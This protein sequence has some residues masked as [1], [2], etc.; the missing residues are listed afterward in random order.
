MYS[1]LHR[2]HANFTRALFVEFIKLVF[3]SL[4]HYSR[5][6][7]LP[8]CRYLVQQLQMEGAD[9]RTSLSL[10]HFPV[11][12]LAQITS[13]LS[14][15]ITLGSL[16][17][18]G[19]RTLG[20]KLEHGGV[21][22]LSSHNGVGIGVNFSLSKRFN[23]LTTFE[24][25]DNAAIGDTM[26]KVLLC[27]PNCILNLRFGSICAPKLFQEIVATRNVDAASAPRPIL[28]PLC[29]LFPNLLDLHF[30]RIGTLSTLRTTE[31]P[32]LKFLKTLPA[33]LTSLSTEELTLISRDL[34][35]HIPPRLQAL[36]G[37]AVSFPFES[38][39]VPFEAA[40]TL[41]TVNIA[42]MD[43]KPARRLGTLAEPPLASDDVLLQKFLFA[44][45][46]NVTVTTSN[47]SAISF[48][49]ALELQELTLH[50]FSTPSKMDFKTI[51][52]RLPPSLTKL[53]TTI[54]IQITDDLLK[55]SPLAN[56]RELHLRTPTVNGA[57]NSIDGSFLNNIF[58]VCPSLHT[59]VLGA[60]SPGSGPLTHFNCGWALNRNIKL[61][62]LE[63]FFHPSFF[64][65]T[66]DTTHLG[67]LASLNSVQ[68][69]KLSSCLSSSSR[70]RIVGVR[71][72]FDNPDFA[73]SVQDLIRL[74]N[75]LQTLHIDELRLKPPIL[76]QSPSSS[77]SASHSAP[78]TVYRY[79]SQES[80]V[81]SSYRFELSPLAP[82][83]CLDQQ[84]RFSEVVLT[85]LPPSLHNKVYYQAVMRDI[86]IDSLPSTLTALEFNIDL[87]AKEDA[88]VLFTATR[89]PHL[90]SLKTT[91][92]PSSGLKDF[93]SLEYLSCPDSRMMLH[94]LPPNL[95][96]LSRIDLSR[97]AAQV[98]TQLPHL[99][100][101]DIGNTEIDGRL[102]YDVYVKRKLTIKISGG[103][104]YSIGNPNNALSTAN[105]S[106]DCIPEQGRADF[107][108]NALLKAYPLWQDGQRMESF[109]LQLN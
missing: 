30:G 106:R 74:P 71:H 66:T 51:L 77:V 40:S 92:F 36:K 70:M 10:A 8:Y 43:S 44:A 102:L 56:L 78:R 5:N 104:C 9:T 19:N 87:L 53:S 32:M 38:S 45:A 55:L 50:P 28:P 59:F 57:A 42:H 39:F 46:Q 97:T 84:H 13:L 85:P 18:L 109:D 17:V 47:L 35:K 67:T 68:H 14:A 3:Q 11:E 52:E 4:L 6:K 2:H 76:P 7:I 108:W 16:L 25:D 34:T 27:L 91:K 72:N 64:A 99:R 107:Y 100:T 41:I 103:K 22:R 73:L 81:F 79:H 33:S 20:Y 37:F 63:G 75:S 83:K 62:R 21:V 82:S 89:F 86:P 101:L 94:Q 12:I 15:S 90:K 49:R 29:D 88:A 31:D 54:P 93:S 65:P 48:G 26:V 80:L 60:S 96:F 23:A 69:L 61:K 24:I 95:T 1:Q 105:I 98:F 58:L